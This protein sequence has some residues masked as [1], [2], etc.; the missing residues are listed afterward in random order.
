[1]AAL[2]MLVAFAS[3]ADEMLG[4]DGARER[5]RVQVS[6][7]M[8]SMNV[9]TRSDISEGLDRRVESLWIA[10]YK[11]DGSGERTG[12]VEVADPQEADHNSHLAE[13][14]LDAMTGSSYIVAVANYGN[15]FAKDADGREFS[16]DKA[17]EQADTWQKFCG[18]SA[19]W[20]SDGT[21]TTDVP[22]NPLLMSGH[23]MEGTHADGGFV[24]IEPVSIPRSGV[25]SGAI[26]LRRLV[27][28]VRFNV[29]CN[30]DNITNFEVLGWKVHNVP[31]HCWLA[32]RG[33]GTLNA[34]DERSHSSGAG[35]YQTTVES[36][37]FDRDG[38]KW[39]FDWWQ[40]ENKRTGLT[41]PASMS[42]PYQYRELE[43]KDASGANT[44]KYCSLVES[45]SSTDPNNY[46]TFVEMKVRMSL[47]VDENGKP[48]AGNKMRVFDGVYTVHLGYCEGSGTVRAMDFNARRN[49]RYTYNVTINNVNNV[50]VEADSD[51]EN[52]PG[53]EGI[54]SDVTDEFVELD[55]HYGVYNIHLT[56][57]DLRV[58]DY[59]IRCYDADGN[60]VLIDSKDPSTVPSSSS[61]NR[62]Y[63]D[64]VELRKTTG[65]NTLSAYQPVSKGGTYRLDEFKT[66][67][68]N[69]TIKA[70]Y[71]TV[72]FNEYVYENTTNGNES[73]GYAWRGY[74]NQP[75][76]QVWI[77]VLEHRS[78]DGESSYFQS[79]YAFSQKSI[80]TYYNSSSSGPATALGVEHVNE[81]YGLNLRASGH[82]T[83]ADNGR[84]NTARYIRNGSWSNNSY[85][86]SKYLTQSTLQSVN[87]IN[88]LGK[89]KEATTYPLPALVKYSGS[90]SKSSYDPDQSSSGRKYIEARNACMNRNRD[91]DGD[92]KIDANELR[93]YVPTTNQTIRIIL[94]RRSLVTP[95]MDYY[96]NSS[97]PSS[98]TGEAPSLIVYG[99]EGNVLWAMEG[100]STSPWGKYYEGFPWNVRCV[101]NLGT[102]MNTTSFTTTVDPAYRFREG[103]T[104]TVEMKNYD[105]KSVRSEKMAKI[106][107]HHIN[108][109]D[110][111]RVYK[112]F[113]YSGALTLGDL[114]GYSSYGSNWT[115]WLRT[116]NPCS[117][118][119]GL[120]GTG[121]R[122]PNQKE[123]TILKTLEVWPS[124]SYLPSATFAFYNNSGVGVWLN[125]SINDSDF[126]VMC[127]TVYGTSTQWP[128]SGFLGSGTSIRCVR[129][130]D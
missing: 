14:E 45:A 75:D 108:D 22:V 83:D 99:S 52:N 28:Q 111:N 107:P 117:G 95:I 78:S 10:V 113:E 16:L 35:S 66:G 57:D 120:N 41:P 76:R 17:L 100:I 49:T 62:K 85:D 33:S 86:W 8:P 97:L 9:M 121:W 130:I 44:G 18:L 105:S 102:N 129:D 68:E 63:L 54:V 126:K 69:G 59:L 125:S 55:A 87:A 13:V 53:A 4:G 65:A 12:L 94:G 106:I 93:W 104:R 123:I 77:R 92:G 81:S 128:A 115:N 72:F 11:A 109:Q 98:T 90:A 88:N 19:M 51:V 30:E 25:L 38:G 21:V 124:S 1:V 48:L 43:F 82:G 60:L 2:V 70:G 84:Y 37:L 39:S 47:K 103:A 110:Y 58:F 5:V 116:V 79:K 29:T 15:R 118:V 36:T 96:S 80:Q 26:H 64:W 119:S 71:Y 40:I 127:T 24:E 3:C 46:A 32:E 23:Y 50:M 6:V 7:D 91:L 67:I 112:A 74:V 34:G 27:S 31:L 101:R 114:N 73:S 56:D 122:I 89:T 61:A 20:S 42:D